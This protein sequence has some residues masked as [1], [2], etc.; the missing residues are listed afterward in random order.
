ME[1]GDAS[2]EGKRARVERS[3]EK[4][5]IVF[6][7]LKNK[8]V[9]IDLAKHC[10][11]NSP[12]PILAVD[13]RV[14]HEFPFSMSSFRF[15]DTVFLVGGGRIAGWHA[16]PYTNRVYE[17]IFAAANDNERGEGEGEVLLPGHLVL[18]PAPS[19]NRPKP[20]TAVNLRGT[21]Y[22]LLYWEGPLPDDVKD[23]DSSFERYDPISKSWITEA[24]P[25]CYVGLFNDLDTPLRPSCPVVRRFVKDDKLFLYCGADRRIYVF[26]H[27]SRNWETITLSPSD[28]RYLSAYDRML[29]SHCPGIWL[30]GRSSSEEGVGLIIDFPC[31]DVK[32]KDTD[33]TETL[34]KP[35][36]TIYSSNG[37]PQYYQVLDEVFSDMYP[38]NS[39]L[40]I[41]TYPHLLDLGQVGEDNQTRICAV[42]T[43]NVYT[44]VTDVSTGRPYI[45]ELTTRLLF[46]SVFDVELLQLTHQIPR[47]PHVAPNTCQLLK[48][49]TV[50]KLVFRLE[51]RFYYPMFNAFVL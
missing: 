23:F 42:M 38:P 13:Y 43:G 3:S 32:L 5:G 12:P 51:K 25:P 39:I 21:I 47:P 10:L 34:E 40:M 50:K 37:V 29:F 49:S 36:A 46:I 17:F 2:R 7:Q 31:F 48:V 14:D 19:L 1:M 16:E 26:S 4:G 11:N 20:V 30:S 8:L 22:V 28:C 24:S 41:D 6:V 35:V 18:R 45:D 27:L 15:E 9:G 44:R 33:P